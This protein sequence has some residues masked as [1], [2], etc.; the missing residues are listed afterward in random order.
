MKAAAF[1]LSLGAL[2]LAASAAAQPHVTRTSV[3]GYALGTGFREAEG[4]S[5]PCN[6]AEA[7]WIAC[8]PRNDVVLFFRADTLR[9]VRWSRVAPRRVTWRGDRAPIPSP[10]GL[11]RERYRARVERDLGPP[12]SVLVSD[13]TAF[14][15]A[16]GDAAPGSALRAVWRWSARWS[17]TVR[18][19]RV[20]GDDSV[21]V[22]E[23]VEVRCEDD[24]CFPALVQARRDSIAREFP[25][26]A[27][28]ELDVSDYDATLGGFRLLAEPPAALG[29]AMR[30][31]DVIRAVVLA[32][33]AY[34]RLARS[35]AFRRGW[36]AGWSALHPAPGARIQIEVQR[37]DST[38]RWVKFRIPDAP[39]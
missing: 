11:W 4:R 23:S 28:E 22:G 29:G 7:G 37:G 1:A 8:R 24:A 38:P 12:D 18:L 3:A 15:F 19:W 31:G 9:A 30:A 20:D 33:G 13:D 35:Q 14:V 2:F 27:P 21:T 17:A 32:P 16:D 36:V 5:L 34:T 39:P 10:G 25:P 6:A 26:M